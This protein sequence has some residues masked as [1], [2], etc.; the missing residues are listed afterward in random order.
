MAVALK[1]GETVPL[2]GDY[3]ALRG[4]AIAEYVR[5]NL[6]VLSMDRV[7]KEGGSRRAAQ[8]F[9]DGLAAVAEALELDA[10]IRPVGDVTE[11][12]VRLR[13]TKR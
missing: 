11:V 4:T 2:V 7:L 6:G 1:R 8:G 3:L 9:V 10:R 13:R 12:E 5:A